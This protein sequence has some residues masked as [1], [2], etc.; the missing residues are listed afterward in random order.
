VHIINLLNPVSKM[1]ILKI[2]VLIDSETVSEFQT[3]E[4]SDFLRSANTPHDCCL[5]TAVTI[6]VVTKIM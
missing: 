3:V 5:S 2:V 6:I 4:E 1:T